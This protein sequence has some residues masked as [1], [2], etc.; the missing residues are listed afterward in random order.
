MSMFKSVKRSSITYI[1]IILFLV[2]F[3]INIYQYIVNHNFIKAT[4]YLQDVNQIYTME[5]GILYSYGEFVSGED[6][7]FT[8]DF[9]N[10]T[11]EELEKQ[12]NVSKIAGEGTPFEK[13]SRLMNEFSG[14]LT[15]ESNY[16]EIVEYEALALLKYSLD[17]PSHGINCR[18]KAQILNEM[19]LSLGIYARK[20]RIMPVSIY[21]NDCHVVNEVYD[22]SLEKW[23][24][25]DI[26]NNEYW[27]NEEGIPLSILEIREC[28]ATQSFCTP[29]KPGDDLTDLHK[30]YETYQG[31]FLYIMKNMV[32]FEYW[33]HYSVGEDL[34]FHVLIP[35]PFTSDHPISVESIL[36]APNSI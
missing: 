18:C 20:I 12:Y 26:T 5:S 16:S 10:E 14:R 27:V 19:C 23:V 28:G 11:Y 29:V 7:Q 4:S 17:Q 35:E 13:A 22:T 15:H 33:D 30:L 6:F 9:K 1:V 25:F 24:M 34:A 8:Y 2:I 3:S 31:D 32:Y 36:R 21:D